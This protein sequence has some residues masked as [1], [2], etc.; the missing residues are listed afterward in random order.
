MAVEDSNIITRDIS[1][2]HKSPDNDVVM[3]HFAIENTSTGVVNYVVAASGVPGLRDVTPRK[4]AC[5]QA[6]LASVVTPSPASKGDMGV[7]VLNN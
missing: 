3:G 1:I 6:S 5:P 7:E 2:L 4:V